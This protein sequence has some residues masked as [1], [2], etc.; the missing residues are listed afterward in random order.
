MRIDIDSS[1]LIL[2]SISETLPSVSV[3]DQSLT[4]MAQSWEMI[5][6]Y[7]PS[8][9]ESFVSCWP[10]QTRFCSSVNRVKD[11]IDLESPFIRYI[12]CLL[13]PVT[14]GDNKNLVD[15]IKFDQVNSIVICSNSERDRHLHDPKIR[16]TFSKLSPYKTNLYLIQSIESDLG[17]RDIAENLRQSL[18][19]I[20]TV[21]WRLRD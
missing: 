7:S 10:M 16:Y 14:Q 3:F 1:L 17:S 15:L 6:C 5:V 8:A 21:K 4:N 13:E 9:L 18:S 20:S 2:K 19:T 12:V 11:Y